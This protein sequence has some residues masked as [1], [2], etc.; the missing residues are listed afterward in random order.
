MQTN[1]YLYLASCALLLALSCQVA[2]G[3]PLRTLGCSDT[4]K[5][6]EYVDISK[7]LIKNVRNLLDSEDLFIGL[8]C[9]E[10][11][12]ELNAKTQTVQACKPNTDSITG[13]SGQQNTGFSESECLR[14]I[15]ADLGHYI[16]SLKAYKQANLDHTVTLTKQLLNFLTQ[17]SEPSSQ[18]ADSKLTSGNSVDQRVHL[19]KVLKGF[20]LRIITISRAMGYISAG[21]HRK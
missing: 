6:K 11:R 3:T 12:V 7:E 15:S 16:A 13:C 10:Q 18:V 1:F 5:S 21:D 14:N 20:H 4:T 8:N 17:Q 2:I 19:C 9:S